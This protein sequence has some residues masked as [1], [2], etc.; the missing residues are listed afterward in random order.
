MQH[1]DIQSDIQVVAFD[2]DGVLFDS[3]EANQAYYNQILRQ[4]NLPDLTAEQFAYVHMHTVDEALAYLF[5]SPEIHLAARAYSRKMTYMPFI[6]NMVMEPHLR[7]LLQWLRPTYKTA[8]A[9]N[10]TNTM[11][12]VLDEHQ[13][14]G[15]FDKVITAADVQHAKPH[16]DQLIA[17]LDHFGAQA[18]QMIYIGDSQVD[19]L[20]AE[21][22]DV[23]F[24]AY[25]NTDLKANAHVHN[26]GQIVQLLRSQGE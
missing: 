5:D 9:T 18:S 8:I 25:R 6:R 22:A 17:L 12:R 21:H 23:Y 1:S 4:F 19:A 2:C 14:Q 3:S 10:R 15:F 13:L 7:P 20:A 11:N 16:P 26:L 24:V